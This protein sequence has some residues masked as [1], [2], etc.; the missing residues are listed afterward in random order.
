MSPK[1]FLGLYFYTTQKENALDKIQCI[2][3]LNDVV[4]INYK[5]IKLCKN[6]NIH[7]RRHNAKRDGK[8]AIIIADIETLAGLISKP[9]KLNT[10]LL[11]D[12]P[13]V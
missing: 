13:H 2:T 11:I 5:A 10:L 1:T 6:N 8:I 9:K 12:T 7:L 3:F 4:L